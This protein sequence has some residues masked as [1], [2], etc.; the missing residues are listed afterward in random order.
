MKGQRQFL[1][2]TQ[3]LVDFKLKSIFLWI[4]TVILGQ[5]SHVSFEEK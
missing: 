2:M 4:Y 3:G 1:T 5:I